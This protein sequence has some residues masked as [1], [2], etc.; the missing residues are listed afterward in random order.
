MNAPGEIDRLAEICSPDIGVITNIGP[1]HLEGVGSIDGVMHA[2]G[3]LVTR[4]KPDGIAIL[5]ADDQR[6][7]NLAPKT[8]MDVL[9]FGKSEQAQ[10]RAKD[11]KK[12]VLGTTFTLAMPEAKISVDLRVPGVF[13]VSNALAAAAVGYRLGITAEKIKTG[14]ESFQP[15]WGRMNILETPKG[16]HIIDD[17]Y[18]ANPVSMEAALETLKELKKDSRGVFVVGDMLELGDH[19]ESMHYRIGAVAVGSAITRLY[20]TGAFA[21]T[22]A[23]GARSENM[24]VENIFTGTKKEILEDLAHWLERGDWILIKGSRGMRMEDIVQG[25]RQWAQE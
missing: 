12:G 23:A 20:A 8:G 2:K 3:E 19:A 21:D 15:V 10:I 22:V 4:I 24:A 13:M 18:N 1:V 17:T 5:N 7:R 9:F 6:V 11:V 14:L 16:I 25:L